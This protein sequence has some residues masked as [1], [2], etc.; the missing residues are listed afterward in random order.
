M[1]LRFQKGSP[2]G[3]SEGGI[4]EPREP[5]EHSHIANTKVLLAMYLEEFGNSRIVIFSSRLG[6]EWLINDLLCP[7]L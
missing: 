3:A 5:R 7:G 6:G 4:K 2:T 1:Q